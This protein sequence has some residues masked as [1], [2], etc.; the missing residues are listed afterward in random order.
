MYPNTRMRRNRKASWLRDLVCENEISTNDLILPLFVRDGINKKE[1]I[2]SMPGIFRFSP[3]K[4]I[5]QAKI[6]ESLGIRAIALFPV[7]DLS[8]KSDDAKEAYN[9]DNL[10]CKT[11]RMIKN[12]NLKIGVI[13]D[14]ALD[15]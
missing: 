11:V 3:D 5:E 13:C 10:I 12:E 6:A 9:I 15:P 2:K 4:I 8:L 14:V 1:E 7:I